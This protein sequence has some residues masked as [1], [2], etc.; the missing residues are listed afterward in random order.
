MHLFSGCFV[1]TASL[2]R[3]CTPC[4][5]SGTVHTALLWFVFWETS[6]CHI[7]SDLIKRLG[8]E[9]NDS[10]LVSITPADGLNERKLLVQVVGDTS[11]NGHLL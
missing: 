9:A 1:S 3:V 5:P 4:L 7:G 10:V 11:G 2:H 8:G 6:T